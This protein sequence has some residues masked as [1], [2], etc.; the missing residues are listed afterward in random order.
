MRW[1]FSKRKITSEPETYKQ[2]FPDHVRTRLLLVFQHIAESGYASQGTFHELLEDVKNRLLREYG[3]LYRSAYQA[4]RRSENPAIEHFLSCPDELVLDFIQACFRSRHYAGKQAGVNEINRVLREEGLGYEFSSYVEHVVDHPPERNGLEGLA[5]I[6]PF[7]LRSRNA[8]FIE[9]TYPEV[10]ERQSE[11]LHDQ[12]IRPCLAVLADS[13]FKVA[14]SEMLKAHEHVRKGNLDDA[15]TCCGAAYESVL[16][17]ICDKKRWVYN[18]SKDSCGALVDICAKEGLFPGFYVDAMKAPGIIRNKLSSAHG[19]G[20]SPEHGL[21]IEHVDHMLQ[22]TSANVVL[23][24][25]LAGL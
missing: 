4:T 11:Y 2:S 17:T 18:P 10:I 9:T 7:M 12:V 8:K 3:S 25:K 23:L 24:V 15:L 6:P 5:S 16:K 13:I 19:R 22:L 14:N 20:P 21:L 1:P